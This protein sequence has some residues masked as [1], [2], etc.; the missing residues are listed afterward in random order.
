MKIFSEQSSDESQERTQ[1][2]SRLWT[3][4]S[5]NWPCSFLQAQN[6][7]DFQAATGSLNV[8]GDTPSAAK[9]H[10]PGRIRVL[11]NWWSKAPCAGCVGGRGLGL[12]TLPIYQPRLLAVVGQLL[13]AVLRTGDCGLELLQAGH[14]LKKPS[15]RAPRVSVSHSR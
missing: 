4:P 11:R 8:Q 10:R 14:V 2:Q 5:V 9:C 12:P 15:I 6:L 1:R 7:C 13:L 3:K